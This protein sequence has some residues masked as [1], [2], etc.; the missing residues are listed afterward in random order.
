M[1]LAAF[2]MRNAAV[3]LPDTLSADAL[4]AT[5]I[6]PAAAT[7]GG[8][9]SFA[10]TAFNGSN[11]STRYAP[12][13]QISAENVD[14]L[15]IAWEFDAGA[16]GPERESTSV[17]TPLMVNGRVYVTAG[18]TRNVVA[19]DAAT[20]QIKW[21]WR[22]DEG[23]RFDAAPRKGSGKG[24]TWHDNNGQETLFTITPGYYLVALDARTGREIESFGKHGWVDLQQGLRRGP[25]R[26]DLDIGMSFMP[27]AVDG[28]VI[29]GAAHLAGWRGFQRQCRRLGADVRRRGTRPGLPARGVRHR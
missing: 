6:T 29:A 17:T 9:D 20:G 8:D 4:L 26:D 18:A 2:L 19:L 24:L 21:M 27:M 15:E 10:W 23:E 1:D 7:E 28:V 13:D 14:E 5:S 3:A 22:P 12:L 16:F 11:A 25:G